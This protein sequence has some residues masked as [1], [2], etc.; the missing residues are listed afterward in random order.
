M[1][2]AVLLRLIGFVCWIG[3]LPQRS[4]AQTWRWAV[5]PTNTAASHSKIAAMAPDKDGTTVVAGSFS[6]TIAFGRFTLSSAGPED[7]FVAQL[8]A[9]GNWLQA[10]RAGSGNVCRV[11]ALMVDNDE[12]TVVGGSFSGLAIDFGAFKLTNADNIGVG[13]SEDLFVARL[14]RAGV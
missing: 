10:V 3:L 1:R 9:A 5:A 14:N 6:G 2:F 12:T 11:N 13:S 7:V 4:A 8:D